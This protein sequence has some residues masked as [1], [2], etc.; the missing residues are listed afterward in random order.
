MREVLLQGSEEHSVRSTCKI[1]DTVRKERRTPRLDQKSCFRLHTFHSENNFVGRTS[2]N[3]HGAY[4]AVCSAPS[5][6]DGELTE[7]VPKRH[8][9]HRATTRYRG[10]NGAG[11]AFAFAR[12]S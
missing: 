2:S 12:R 3:I 1:R 5:N 8:D 4:K 10:E 7:H 9:D 11:T 6:R